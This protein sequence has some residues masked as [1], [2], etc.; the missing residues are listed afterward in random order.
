MSRKVK[1]QKVFSMGGGGAVHANMMYFNGVCLRYVLKSVLIR[2]LSTFNF[3]TIF[4][5]IMTL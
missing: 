2:Y 4:I 3:I 1:I 5:L